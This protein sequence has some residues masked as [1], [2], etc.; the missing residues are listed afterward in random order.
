MV[1][2]LENNP[3]MV[4]EGIPPFDKMEAE[5]VVPAMNAVIVDTMKRIEEIEQN[6]EP[7]WAGVMQPMEDLGLAFS[8]AWSPVSHLLSVKNPAGL[9][10]CQVQPVPCH[11]CVSPPAASAPPSTF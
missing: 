10:P 3:F 7:T 8:Y 9:G 5:H 2:D 4:R 1:T 11:P 6:L